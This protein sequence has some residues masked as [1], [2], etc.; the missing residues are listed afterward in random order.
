MSRLWEGLERPA[1][2]CDLGR[3]RKQHSLGKLVVLDL[4]GG[5]AREYIGNEQV[6]VLNV[7]GTMQTEAVKA[8]G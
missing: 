3:L 5:W 6:S 8:L 7:E 1:T 4:T 2:Q